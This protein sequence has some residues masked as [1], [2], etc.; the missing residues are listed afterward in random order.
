MTEKPIFRG[1]ATALIT[2]MNAQGVDY[3]A[4][5][6]LIDWQCEQGINAI[7]IAGTTGEGSTLDDADHKAVVKFAIERIAGRCV[8]IAATGSNDTAYAVQLSKY[9]CDIG[10]DA[11]LIVTPYYN[12]TTQGGLVKM[13]ETIADAS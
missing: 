2:P 4:L 7:V 5:G 13:Y 9:C 8:S 11:L 1:V 10:A 3:D 12:K 6:R